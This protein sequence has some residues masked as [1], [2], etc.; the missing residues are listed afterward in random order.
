VTEY[1]LQSFLER[2]IKSG[3]EFPIK[4]LN[5]DDLIPF[6]ILVVILEFILLLDYLNIL[7]NE[8]ETF[9]QEVS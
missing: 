3:I 6:K 5:F 4:V 2:L 8:D 9:G 7:L 1:F